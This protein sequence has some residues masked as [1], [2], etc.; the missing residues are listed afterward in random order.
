MRMSWI[1]CAKGLAMLMVVI[2]HASQV[3]P[4]P[5]AMSSACAFGAMGVQLFFLVSAYCLCLTC[6]NTQGGGYLK[7]LTHKY[8]RL[9]PWYVGGIFI[10][11]GWWLLI[12]DSGKLANFT[13]GNVVANLLMIND[14]I[15]SA[16]NSIV[17]G[18]WSISCIAMFAFA[19][20]LFVRAD[21]EYRLWL[22]AVLSIF[23]LFSSVVGYLFLGWSRFY[24]YCCPTNQFVV[25]ALGVF[26]WVLRK[27]MKIDT[28][29]SL[30]VFASFL[31]LAIVSVMFD[32]EHAILYRQ[33]L[34]AIAFMGL[35]PI[36]EH[37]DEKLPRMLSWIG[38]HSYEIFI[39][40]FVVIWAIA[41]V[42]GVLRL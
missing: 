28:F 14:F 24:A 6:K 3:M 2:I 37:Y 31:A 1:D 38:R 9:S 27:R 33:V 10:Y 35:L 5:R 41:R 4:L 15:P 25:F 39:L 42:L 12:G 13:I 16:Q 8:Q 30:A 29:V 18:G 32:K 20:P 40:H 11:L 17:P 7:Y 26:Y 23:G 22:L 21:G 34:C 36:L 19:F